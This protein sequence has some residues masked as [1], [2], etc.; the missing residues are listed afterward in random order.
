[1]MRKTQ[2]VL[3]GVLVTIVLLSVLSVTPVFAKKPI[4]SDEVQVTSFSWNFKE[5]GG[6][7][8]NTLTVKGTIETADAVSPISVTLYI[9]K[10]DDNGGSWEETKV[11]DPDPS[12]NFGFKWWGFPAGWYEATVTVEYEGSAV[13]TTSFVF[14]PPGGGPGPMY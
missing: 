10:I 7:T 14:D 6:K 8:R 5:G 9:E 13:W 12:F 3:T 4:Y 11:Y 2:R 1:M